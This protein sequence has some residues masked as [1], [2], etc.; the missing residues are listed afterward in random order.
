MSI[1]NLFIRIFGKTFFEKVSTEEGISKRKTKQDTGSKE[2]VEIET[3]KNPAT[4]QKS[5]TRSEE[6]CLPEQMVL[7]KSWL[8]AKLDVIEINCRDE[9]SNQ[10]IK[11]RSRLGPELV[12]FDIDFSSTVRI[13]NDR[14]SVRSQGSF[15]TIKANV[16]IFGGKWMYE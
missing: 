1:A 13:T 15:N 2:D 5:A 16:C 12:I 3:A 4:F 6:M 8:Q 11:M 7:V 14:L 10:Q 9:V